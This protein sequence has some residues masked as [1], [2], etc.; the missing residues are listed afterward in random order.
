MSHLAWSPGWRQRGP[1][2]AITSL[3]QHQTVTLIQSHSATLV[4]ITTTGTFG[5]SQ[6]RSD[7]LWTLLGDQISV[8]LNICSFLY[9]ICDQTWIVN[10]QQNV[11]C[12][13]SNIYLFNPMK[14]ELK[15][16]NAAAACVWLWESET[17]WQNKD[18]IK[19]HTFV[20]LREGQRVDQEGHSKV[21]YRL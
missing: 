13:I 14:I 17:Q 12:I 9:L 4:I 16:D 21:I 5:T 18:D 3:E 2:G 6:L 8:L 11:I 10:Y 19:K 20:K 15:I 7:E 1:C